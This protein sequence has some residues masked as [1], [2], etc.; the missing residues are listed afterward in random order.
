MRIEDLDGPRAEARFA[1]AALRDL[2]WLGLDWDGPP[3]LQSSGLL[4]LNEAVA[5]LVVAG[6]AYPC[7]CSRSDVRNAQSAPHACGGGPG[8]ESVR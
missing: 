5:Q 6:K 3:Y 7:V 4:R 2:E 1:D 8:G